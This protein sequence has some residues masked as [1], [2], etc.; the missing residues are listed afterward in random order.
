MSQNSR[1]RSG[2]PGNSGRGTNESHDRTQEGFEGMNYEQVRQ[3][4]PSKESGNNSSGDRGD[5][6]NDSRSDEK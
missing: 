1:N 6:G 2:E 3:P 4:F 5:I